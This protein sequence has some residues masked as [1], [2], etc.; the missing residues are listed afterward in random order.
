MKFSRRKFLQAGSAA[1][2]GSA[3]PASAASLLKGV[4]LMN[5]AEL[6]DG[7]INAPRSVRSSCYW[8]WFNGLVDKE[9]ITRDLEEFRAKGMGEVLL[10]NSS[11]G[12]GGVPFPQGAHFLSEEWKALYRHAMSEAKRLDIGVGINLSSGWCMGGPWIKPEDSG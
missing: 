11:G 4:A 3:L 7:F 8:W 10:V 12:L 9:G 2:L 5:L 1:A 6:A